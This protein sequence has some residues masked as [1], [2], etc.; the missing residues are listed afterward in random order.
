MND[1][2]S[3]TPPKPLSAATL[4]E[5]KTR[6]T[7]LVG[8][9]IRLV[10]FVTM[11]AAFATGFSGIK[12]LMTAIGAGESLSMNSFVWTLMGLLAFTFLFGRFFCGYVCAFG[13]LG[14]AVYGLS[15]WI[16]KKVFHRKK[17]LVFPDKV[18]RP[19]QKVKY[20]VLAV[21]VLLCALGS[22]SLLTGWSPWD[23]FSR[24]TAFQWPSAGYIGGIVLLVLIVIGMACQSRFFCQFLCPM[25]AVF[26]LMPVLPFSAVTS[27]SENCLKGC[28]A[29]RKN[30]PVGIKPGEDKF[31]DGECVACEK[32][33][34]VCPKGNIHRPTH[35]I[36]RHEWVSLVLKAV[37]FFVM[38]V[39]LGLCRFL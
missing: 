29:C 39:F 30:C 12:Y 34:H 13:T 28:Q 8:V 16:Q 2:S 21:L 1:S 4:K 14:D 20:V 27:R 24:L 38:G 7:M 10:F 23:V 11:P 31:L 9:G 3:Q 36:I 6:L 26:S 25:G 22:Y 33:M 18:Y 32:C 19:L 5:R 15:A 37:L 17:P 35:K